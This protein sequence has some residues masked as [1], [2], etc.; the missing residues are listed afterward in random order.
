MYKNQFDIFCK[1]HLKQIFI[2]RGEPVDSWHSSWVYTLSHCRVVADLNV[3][4]CRKPSSV[5]LERLYIYNRVFIFK[6]IQKMRLSLSTILLLY[7]VQ[8]LPS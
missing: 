4:N 3:K 6:Y 5:S 7:T 1:K 8:Q 2:P